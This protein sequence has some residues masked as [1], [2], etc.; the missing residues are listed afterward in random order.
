MADTLTP[1]LQLTNQ[2]EGGNNNS[3]GQ[4]A[5]AN[6]ERIDDKLGDTTA[7]VTT[8]GTTTLTST[9]EFVQSIELSGTLA[10]NATIAFSGRGGLWAVRNGTVGGSFTMT[11]KV[12][13]QTGVV[14]AAGDVLV[15]YC[16]SVDIKYANQAATAQVVPIGAVINTAVPT[17]AATGW[18]FCYGQDLSRTTYAALFAAIGVT[19]GIGNGTTTFTLPDLRGRVIAGKDDMGGVSANRLTGLSGGINGDTLGGTGGTE[20]NT[21]V[22]GQIPTIT[23]TSGTESQTHTH[24]YTTRS[25]ASNNAGT[26]NGVITQCNQGTSTPNTGNASVTHTHSLSCG[27]GSPSAVN[28]V[29]PTFVLNKIIYHG[30]F[31]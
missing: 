23:G 26:D 27:S 13:G 2:T 28:N 19:Y 10:S 29:Q 5:D 1:N 16:N 12:T 8:G 15:V 4:I 20:S 9:Q 21:L 17:T 11:L 25:T 22:A 30:V 3:W 18:V 7:I 6:F 24:T 14:I 31:S